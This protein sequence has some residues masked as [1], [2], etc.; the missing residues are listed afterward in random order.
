M[1][2]SL[3]W[4]S[5]G[6]LTTSSLGWL[7]SS[8]RL[9]GP[10][11]E[12]RCGGCG[13][14]RGLVRSTFR[15]CRRRRWSFSSQGRARASAD[16][17]ERGS[18]KGALHWRATGRDHR[19]VLR[20]LLLDRREPRCLG[21]DPATAIH[22]ARRR[23]RLAG[24][25]L[26]RTLRWLPLRQHRGRLAL[27]PRPAH[28]RPAARWYASLLRWMRIVRHHRPTNSSPLATHHSPLTSHH[29]P[30]TTQVRQSSP[31]Y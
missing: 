11:S 20:L 24:L 18:A 7:S 9:N 13:C 2:L 4:L 28:P 3:G 12:R 17:S 14:S 5:L 6:W 16:G 10:P 21:S 26:R 1:R 23:G 19:L 29:P 25:P 31:Y 15:G 8:T 30:L 22:R 27:R